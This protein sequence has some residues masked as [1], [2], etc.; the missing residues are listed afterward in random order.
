MAKKL[1]KEIDVADRSAVD[2]ISSL[3]LQ[4][5]KATESTAGKKQ[6]QGIEPCRERDRSGGNG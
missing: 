5:V 6:P 3:P 1:A 2:R 4:W